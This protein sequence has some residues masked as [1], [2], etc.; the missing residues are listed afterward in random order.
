MTKST[1]F[2]TLALS[3]ALSVALSGMIAQPA[4]AEAPGAATVV[5]TVNGTEI[6]L[7]Q[8][9]VARSALPPEYQSMPDDMLFGGLLDQLIQQ[10][11][12]EQSLE[13]KLTV[14][15]E[16]T[17]QNERLAYLAAKV[18]QDIAATALTEAAVQKAYDATYTAFTP[19]TEYHASHILVDSEDKAKDLLAQIE[20]GADFAK[21]AIENS[22]DGSAQGGGD[23]GW[24]GLGK[25]VAP[26][27]AAVV[28]AEVGKVVGPVK[29]E[30]GWHLILVTET[31]SSRKPALEDMRAA[32]EAEVKKAAVVAALD[33]L[34]AAATVTRPGERLD[35]ALLK[36]LTLLD[37]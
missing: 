25:M 36:D 21:F 24:F 23:L 22:T 31:R 6:T 1:L 37:K 4:F 10:V 32:L 34:V 28:A 19:E 16:M 20:G 15:D 29:T 5:A 14:L 3:G 7:G 30:F 26:F 18:V 12:I 17:I 35:P 11:A 27:E 2:S 13:G 33:A 8:L 9:I